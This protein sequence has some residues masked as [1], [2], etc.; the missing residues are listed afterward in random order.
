MSGYPPPP[1][2]GLWCWRRCCLTYPLW[3]C[4]A[5]PEDRRSQTEGIAEAQHG[6]CLLRSRM[7]TAV[8]PQ[9]SVFAAQNLCHLVC[10]ALPSG[11]GVTEGQLLACGPRLGCGG[12]DCTAEGREC[13]CHLPRVSFPFAMRAGVPSNADA[14]PPLV[15]LYQVFFCS[16]SP[17]PNVIFLQHC[18]PKVLS[19][20][21]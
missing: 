10:C 11:F 16:V 20:T 8:G 6:V 13:W 1:P 21:T 18:T 12:R 9:T 17:P 5:L 14:E 15:Q 4:L 3:Y 19:R 7:Q 2:Q